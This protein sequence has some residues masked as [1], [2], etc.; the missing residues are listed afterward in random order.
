MR[1]LI[2]FFIWSGLTIHAAAANETCVTEQGRVDELLDGYTIVEDVRAAIAD[3][4]II[5]GLNMF[6]FASD[7]TL[8]MKMAGAIGDEGRKR[9]KGSY[10]IGADDNDNKTLCFPDDLSS[11]SNSHCGLL[12][13]P[14]AQ[15]ETSPFKI[16]FSCENSSGSGYEIAPFA[17]SERGTLFG[18]AVSGGEDS[19]RQGD[20]QKVL[21]AAN[22]QEMG[23]QNDGYEPISVIDLKLDSAK[24][25]NHK[26]SVRGKLGVLGDD[27]FLADPDQD[28][29]YS[30][31][32]V[33]ISG[34]TRA[35]RK[36]IL[37]NCQDDC[38]ITVNGVV[39]SDDIGGQKVAAQEISY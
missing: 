24:L 36:Y 27:A 22:G 12:F 18:V 39:I 3:K 1:L 20:F 30:Q 35:D 31:V 5:F 16:A 8:Y 26:I 23:V 19:I 7:G 28:A 13:E 34:L 4:W 25:L 15:E 17:V 14:T 21:P 32:T 6:D 37:Q 9:W 11:S 2:S 33:D 38:E 10:T 29:D